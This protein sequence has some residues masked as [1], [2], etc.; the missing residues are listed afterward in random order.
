MAPK[1]LRCEM[2][3]HFWINQ[4]WTLRMHDARRKQGFS[5]WL[6]RVHN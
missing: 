1:C 3:F 2:I 6:A 5:L 4:L